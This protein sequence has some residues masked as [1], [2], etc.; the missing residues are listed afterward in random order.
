MQ[1]NIHITYEMYTGRGFTALDEDRF[2]LYITRA[3]LYIQ[4]ITFGRITWLF[5]PP[6]IPDGGED[7]TPPPIGV[8]DD[9]TERNIRGI[10]DLADL[11]FRNEAAISPETGA[12]IISFTNEGYRET[13]EGGARAGSGT[14][15]DSRL[16]RILQ[17]YFTTAQLSRRFFR[18]SGEDL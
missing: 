15:F 7:A 10:C 16:E 3:G 11:F 6:S 14:L 5:S 2:S 18:S 12:A 8:F 13:Y 17:T 4:E 9:L 1:V